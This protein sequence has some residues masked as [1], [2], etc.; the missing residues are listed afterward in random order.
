VGHFEKP[1]RFNSDNPT[2]RLFK[3]QRKFA[4]RR[5]AAQ[6]SFVETNWNY[7]CDLA[8]SEVESTLAAMPPPLREQARKIPVTF[9]HQ[10]NAGLLADG[11]EPDTLGLFT[12]SEFAEADSGV[13]PSQIMLFLDNLWA[14][15]EG[16]EAAFRDEIRTTF[17]HELGHFLGLDEDDLADRGLD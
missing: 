6:N 7:L 13:I 17:L 16:D 3:S 10:P 9:E 8:R 1:H 15:V 5:S 14:Y 12:G 11:I 2:T 4:L